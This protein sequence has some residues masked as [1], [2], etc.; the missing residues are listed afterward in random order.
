M[1]PG[2]IDNDKRFRYYEEDAALN[3]DTVSRGRA[4]DHSWMLSKRW[5]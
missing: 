2:S 3:G 4:E 5:I 1:Y